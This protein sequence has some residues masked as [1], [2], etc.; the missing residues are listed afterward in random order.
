MCLQTGAQVYSEGAALVPSAAAEQ[1]CSQAPGRHMQSAAIDRRPEST[2]VQE[3]PSVL[4]DDNKSREYLAAWRALCLLRQRVQALGVN[5][6]DVP[7]RLADLQS[8]AHQ[9]VLQL[10]GLAP[11]T[12]DISPR[13]AC[14]LPDS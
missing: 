6:F 2:V 5:H 9:T 1:A 11:G 12:A 4:T 7:L 13:Q 14:A 3:M 10:M 8:A